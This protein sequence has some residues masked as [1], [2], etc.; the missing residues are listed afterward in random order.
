MAALVGVVG[1]LVFWLIDPVAQAAQADTFAEPIRCLGVRPHFEQ[2][3]QG[4]VRSQDRVYFA[5]LVIFFLALAR[6][7]LESLRWR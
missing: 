4:L 3:L 6:T 2:L 7:S 5:I 1:G